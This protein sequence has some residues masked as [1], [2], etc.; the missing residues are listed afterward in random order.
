MPLAFQLFEFLHREF[1]RVLGKWCPDLSPHFHKPV[2]SFNRNP[3]GNFKHPLGGG[4][5]WFFFSFVLRC[6]CRRRCRVVHLLCICSI[7]ALCC[8]SPLFTDLLVVKPVLAQLFVDQLPVD[9]DE[10]SPRS[11]GDLSAISRRSLGD[12]SVIFV[13]NRG[14]PCQKAPKG[15]DINSRRSG[16]RF[17]WQGQGPRLWGLPSSGEQTDVDSS[18]VH[19][20]LRDRVATHPILRIK[21]ER[22]RP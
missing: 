11:L 10:T 3:G 18:F 8:L 7:P 20:H 15:S 9:L 5:G 4:R 6:R 13:L 1:L 2:P 22:W 14:P 16:R 12:L 19:R 21:L 17:H